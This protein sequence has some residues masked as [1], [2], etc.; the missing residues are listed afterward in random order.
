MLG[1]YALLPWPIMKAIKYSLD[2]NEGAVIIQGKRA[3]W[4]G[5]RPQQPRQRF[6]RQWQQQSRQQCPFPSN[7]PSTQGL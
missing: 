1:L 4:A 6:Q 5:A 7:N 2:S 3:T